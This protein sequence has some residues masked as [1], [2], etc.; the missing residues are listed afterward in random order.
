VIAACDQLHLPPRKFPLSLAGGVLCNS[1]LMRARLV[2]ALAAE[3]H[4]TDAIALVDQ[5]VRGAVRLARRAAL[6]Q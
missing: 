4:L 1:P 6:D 5:P 2:A 3:D